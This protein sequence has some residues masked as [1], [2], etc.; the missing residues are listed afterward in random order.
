MNLL[1]LATSKDVKIKQFWLKWVTGVLGVLAPLSL[2]GA[3]PASCVFFA[4][5]MAQEPL[6]DPNLRQ[7]WALN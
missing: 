7:M 2:G 6:F 4:P 5:K 1:K 3:L